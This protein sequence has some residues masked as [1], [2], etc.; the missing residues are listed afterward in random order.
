[1]HDLKN[2]SLVLFDGY[3]NLCSWSVH[4]IL[5]KDKKRHF[6][7]IPMQSKK[8]KTLL[9]RYS[10]NEQ[11]LRTV[12]LLD[13]GAIY[14]KS[15]AGLRILK[16]LGFPWNISWVLML[17]PRYFR[18]LVYSWIS[19]GRYRWFGRRVS[20]YIPENEWKDRFI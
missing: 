5:K 7:F 17:V 8:A 14:T 12:I 11:Y 16:K 18:D 9:Q 2:H 15:E 6:R 19:A 10:M 3:C 1:M 13:E 20:C 4:W